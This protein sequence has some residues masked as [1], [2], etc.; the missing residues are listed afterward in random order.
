MKKLKS[1]Y[2]ALIVLIIISACEDETNLD[3][4][5]DVALPSNVGANYV[6]TQDNSGLV[7]IIPYAE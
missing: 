2:K 5:N 4:L 7:T 1:I 6:I 3:F